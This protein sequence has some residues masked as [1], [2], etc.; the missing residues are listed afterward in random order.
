MDKDHKDPHELDQTTSCM[1]Q[2]E[3]VENTPGYGVL[4]RYTACSTEKIEVLSNKMQ[5]NHPL[6]YTP[7]LLYLE[8]FNDGNWRNHIRESIC[9]LDHHDDFFQR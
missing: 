4:G 5:C 6:G 8:S 2:A 9:H 7:S 1:V 3:E